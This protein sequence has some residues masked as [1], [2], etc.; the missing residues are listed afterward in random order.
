MDNLKNKWVKIF[1]YKLIRHSENIFKTDLFS[2]IKIYLRYW[3][4]H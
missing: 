2:H 4:V 3:L 1:Q